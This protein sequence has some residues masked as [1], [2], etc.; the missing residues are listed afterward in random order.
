[1]KQ[2]QRACLG[3]MGRIRDIAQRR[4]DVDWRRGGTMK[5]K[6]RR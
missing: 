1:M 3:S 4:G 5:G 6:E 2:R